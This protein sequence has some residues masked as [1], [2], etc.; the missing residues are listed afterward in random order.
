MTI[1][2]YKVIGPMT[3]LKG[4]VRRARNL[5]C[6]VDVIGNA[7]DTDQ[8]PDNWHVLVL[9]WLQLHH[10]REL[11]KKYPT[12]SLIEDAVKALGLPL[13]ENDHE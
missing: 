9:S 4:E 13:K 8:A 1:Q 7:I 11:K 6:I 5:G 12:P 2:P 10:G 3:I